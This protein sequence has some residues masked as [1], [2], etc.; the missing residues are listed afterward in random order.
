MLLNKT[1]FVVDDDEELCQSVCALVSSLGGAAR[2]FASAEAFLERYDESLRG[3]VVVDL[4][5]PGMS[6]LE[7]QAELTRRNSHLPV[8]VLTAFART[9]TTVR[10]MKAGA[11]TIID[12]PYRDDELWD[13]IRTALAHEEA[14]WNVQKRRQ[15]IHR[16]LLTLSA[17]ER[18]VLDRIVEGKLN[19]VIAKE[20]GLAVRT[21]EK[22]RHDV[23]AKMGA[24]SIAEL[25]GMALEARPLETSSRLGP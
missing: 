19:K 21:V 2:A 4:R 15:E 5:M 20:L 16:R 11:V 13:A 25:V 17:E 23:L 24:G 8:I 22:R 1:V 3:V 9:P 7:L 12:K 14:A 6:G 10:A 18:Q